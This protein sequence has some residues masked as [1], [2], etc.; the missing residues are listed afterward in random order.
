M[1]ENV[2]HC[3]KWIGKVIGVTLR[4]LLRPALAS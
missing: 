3:L 1:T 4:A 2:H